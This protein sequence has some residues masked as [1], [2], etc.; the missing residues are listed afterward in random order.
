MSSSRAA[1]SWRARCSRQASWTSSTSTSIRCCWAPGSPCFLATDAPSTS[2]SSRSN[3]CHA[4]AWGWPIGPGAEEDGMSRKD[5]ATIGV[6]DH[7]GW[8]VMIT[9]GGDG[10]LLDRRRVELVAE[11]LPKHPHHHEGQTLPLREG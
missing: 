11:D 1:A 5:S 10:A 2:S 6:A 7:S 9:V 8:A 3:R 4:G